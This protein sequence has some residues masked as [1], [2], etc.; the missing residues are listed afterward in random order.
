MCETRW[1]V[2]FFFALAFIVCN[3]PDAAS[4]SYDVIQ[5]G[6]QQLSDEYYS[7][8]ANAGDIDGDGVTDVV[9]GPY[10]YRG[11]EFRERHEIYA[12]V[13]QDRN[14]YAD[15]FFSWVYDFDGDHHLDV[16]VVGFP[17]TPAYV[18]QNPRVL[19]QLSTKAESLDQDSNSA[20]QANPSDVSLHRHWAKYQVLDWVSNESPQFLDVVGDETPELVCTRDGFFGFAVLN[21]ETP[22]EPWTFY[23]ISDQVAP[24]RFGHGLGVGDV[25]G[26][27]RLDLL[28][29]GGW[30][31]QP[32]TNVTS[33]RWKL[34][35]VSFSQSYGGAEMYAYD[36]D[37][38][39]DN[40]VLTGHAAHDFGL[41]WYENLG[42]K[43]G[44]IAFQHHLIMGDQPEMN[45]YGLVVSELH[46]LAL[47]D[48][49]GD[50]LKDLITG[51]TFWSHHKQSPM[52]D[53]PPAVYVFRLVRGEG[54]KVDWVPYLAGDQSGVGRQLTVCDLNGDSLPDFVVGGMKGA[55]VL[56]QEKSVVTIQEWLQKQPKL[57]EPMSQRMDR[58]PDAEFDTNGNVPFAIEAESMQVISQDLTKFSTQNMRGFSS[59]RWS[60]DSQIFWRAGEDGAALE[61]QFQVDQA[62]E[63][64][65]AA[66]FTTARDYAIINVEIDGRR[67]ADSIDLYHYPDVKTTGL[68]SLGSIRLVEGLHLLKL[69]VVGKNA[70]AVQSRYVG[71]DCIVVK[72][73]I[74]P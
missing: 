58:G 30:F 37:G 26:D 33:S 13:P 43:D 17:G 45:R 48:V 51:K 41:G 71:V 19:D 34:H 22:L 11:P 62:G 5:Y 65:V 70:S 46:S 66:I 10:W 59:A 20:S 68:V 42:E 39:G 38:D 36:V 14:R 64:D 8:G 29:S 15:N 18:Y 7:E 25:N 32:A 44:E 2:G 35:S 74:E 16:L 1:L 52:W 31:E 55:H 4:Q 21:P 61:L 72:P 60:G 27:D 12:P 24:P 50:G 40:D 57:Y 56:I 49:D 28:F 69:I 53:A 54:G 3:P 9:C 6:T 47:A 63:Y 23:P 73:K 67:V